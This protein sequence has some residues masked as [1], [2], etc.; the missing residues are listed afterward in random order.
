MRIPTIVLTLALM[1]E[2][3]A[4]A[5]VLEDQALQEQL[6]PESFKLEAN[7]TAAKADLFN[8]RTTISYTIA[9]NSGMNLYMGIMMG[10]VSMGSCTD[11]RNAHGGL[12]LLPGPNAVAY[13][14]D[15]TVGR[16]RPVYVPAGGRVSGTLIAEDCSAPNPGSPKAPLSFSLMI[17]KT[18]S[19]KSMTQVSLSVDAPIRQLRGQ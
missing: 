1:T 2:G 18:E 10:S 9:N 3:A 4:F 16:P 5:Q 19:S 7:A 8:W 11:V 14:V 17:G 15:L 12:A 13:A 6:V